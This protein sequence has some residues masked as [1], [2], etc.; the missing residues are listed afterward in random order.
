MK[1]VVI[2]LGSMGRRR[3]RLLKQLY[4][5]IEVIGLDINEERRKA[6]E[7]EFS[8]RTYYNLGC[9]DEK[10]DDE[11]KTAFICTSPLSHSKIIQ[12]CLSRGYHIFTEI[13]L[14]DDGYEAN[15]RLAKDNGLVLFLSSTP[16][17]RKEI[18]YIKSRVLKSEHRKTYIYHVGQYLPDWH[19]WENYKDFFV[20]NKR[21]SGCREIMAIEFPWLFDIYGVPLTWV[22][23][24]YKISSLDID[25]N[26]VI[27][28]MFTHPNGCSGI[29][30]FDVVSRKAIRNFECVAEDLYISWDGTPNGLFQYDYNKKE[31]KPISMYN[32]ID[33]SNEYS[34]SIIEN[35]YMDEI[36]VFFDVVQGLTIPRYTFMK[37]KEI[38]RII[39]EIG[40]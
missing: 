24:K 39:N 36:K 14:N 33:K 37:D 7:I 2:G 16:M 26:D 3:V 18:E 40:N 12:E 19:P 9:I 35:A 10:I 15:I 28:I 20:S 38:L 32:Y 31:G 22:T 11:L 17:Y 23:N 34:D 8:I 5:N 13:N 6:A 29:I 21:T 4:T 27:Q 1:T 25:Y 30:Q